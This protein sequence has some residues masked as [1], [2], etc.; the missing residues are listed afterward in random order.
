M[1]EIT[2][3][4]SLCRGGCCENVIIQIDVRSLDDVS[5][6]FFPV[7]V[8][9]LFQV[10]E[11]TVGI[12]LGKRCPQL[13]EEGRCSI[14]EQRP[15]RCRDYQAGSEQCFKVMLSERP[16]VF[17]QIVADAVAAVDNESNS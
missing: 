14:Y 6:E 4:C 2:D 17:E 5:R 1:L 15:R 8:P 3:L 11:N 16:Q 13:T 10:D 9:G 7:R 12:P